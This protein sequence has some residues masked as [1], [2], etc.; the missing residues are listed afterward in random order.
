MVKRIHNLYLL[1]HHPRSQQFLDFF[2]SK[3]LFLLLSVSVST[4]HYYLVFAHLWDGE[5]S[6]KS[7]HTFH[8][9]ILQH[10]TS[11]LVISQAAMAV[12]S[13]LWLVWLFCVYLESGWILRNTCYLT[14]RL[15]QVS[16]RALS[17][18]IFL[19]VLV[20]IGIIVH[21]HRHSFFDAVHVHSLFATSMMI[22][23][24]WNYLGL[25]HGVVGYSVLSLECNE[26]LVFSSLLIFCT[27][28]AFMP[29]ASTLQE[30]AFSVNTHTL[31]PLRK[32]QRAAESNR[33]R[34]LQKDGSK[35][36][37]LSELLENTPLHTSDLKTSPSS[38][39]ARQLST[40][41]A[42]QAPLLLQHR[43]LVGETTRDHGNEAMISGRTSLWNSPRRTPHLFCLELACHMLEVSY[44][45]YFASD[46][47]DSGA[48]PAQSSSL[49][50]AEHS[51]FGEIE[52]PRT[53]TTSQAGSALSARLGW[54]TA[55]TEATAASTAT[56]MTTAPALEG[57]YGRPAIDLARVG[58]TLEASFA[59]PVFSTFGLIGS[60][61]GEIV[62]AFRGST[63]AN[64]VT[65]FHF[66]L[67]ALPELHR[68]PVDLSRLL[69]H[70]EEEEN[71]AESDD[72][73]GEGNDNLIEDLEA[74]DPYR[75]HSNDS[76]SKSNRSRRNSSP[77]KAVA[78]TADSAAEDISRPDH[79]CWRCIMGLAKNL[80]VVKQSFARVHVGFWQAYAS[81]R[82]QYMQEMIRTLFQRFRAIHEHHQQVQAPKKLDFSSADAPPGSNPR[83]LYGAIDAL[84]S[85]S[86]SSSAA[87]A[88]SLG[89]VYFTGHSLGAA[90]TVLA[91]LEL[92]TNMK[93][94]LNLFRRRLPLQPHI[95]VT[96]PEIHIYCFGCPRIGNHAFTRLV[97]RHVPTCYRVVVDGDLVTMVPKFLGFYRHVGLPV[98]LDELATGSIVIEPS[99]LDVSFFKRRV[100]S[101]TN[102]SL[103]KYRQCLEACFEPED[104]QEYLARELTWLDQ[105]SPTETMRT[106]EGHGS[107]M[108]REE[109][110]PKT[111]STTR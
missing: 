84:A 9:F 109:Q 22:T 67:M 107:L 96:A 52:M 104:L 65:D 10:H 4:L 98:L 106:H 66:T 48:L 21:L 64:I 13:C 46:K 37:L 97:A 99:V 34:Q 88:A 74:N 8:G 15:R 59:S 50:T 87:A 36:S 111:S 12:I 40:T 83:G 54:S 94:L 17:F 89:V 6:D 53:S 14:S 71:E 72:V 41:S 100:G 5:E 19:G 102:H 70:D 103:E 80:P 38:T 56:G 27:V 1:K 76:S 75:D 33:A 90:M 26:I 42:E 93:T 82:D 81:V 110:A 58:L 68:S 23:E 79:C 30:E 73:H 91:A 78:A 24:W 25:Y 49:S 101:I 69:P 105:A 60:A 47:I 61:P 11:L 31:V 44:Q 28:Y 55:R 62:V 45:T 63:L 95:S 7:V 18:Q 3:F 32:H 2:F 39:A 43:N 35:K 29:P 92:A 85:S 51:R 57:N 77:R 16:Y 86:F 20:A 108:N